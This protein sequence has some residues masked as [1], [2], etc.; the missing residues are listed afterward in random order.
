M[1]QAPRTT[2]IPGPNFGVHFRQAVWNNPSQWWVPPS[3]STPLGIVAAQDTAKTWTA[4]TWDISPTF[5]IGK[6]LTAFFRYARGFRSGTFNGS[7]TAQ[8]NVSVVDPETV[9]DYE[10]GAKGS[11]LQRRLTVSVA[12]FHYDYQNI[13]VLVNALTGAG[14]TTTATILQNAGSATVNGAE[15][16][17]DSLPLPSFRLRGNLGLLDAW[18]GG[19][20]AVNSGAVVNASG[21]QLVRAPH[22]TG[23]LDGEYRIALPDS[24]AV[25]IGTDWE[26]RGKQYFNA[27]VQNNINLE[28]KDYVLG[29]ARV[30]YSTW[31]D[32][33][34]LQAW[35]H[36]LANAEYKI[37]GTQ[38]APGYNAV[39]FGPPRTF[40]VTATAR[41]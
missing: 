3:V 22:E 31:E 8:S 12:G 26:Y 15:I 30:T 2:L 13:Q 16:E 27:V 33:L 32:R 14:A 36:N 19:F 41:F 24:T 34:A 39:Y 29:N 4:P 37:L 5:N 28:E 20:T 9:D 17:F 10:I 18:Y 1:E 40:G 25:A 11:F 6:D 35:V 21:N 23:M 38:G 7:V